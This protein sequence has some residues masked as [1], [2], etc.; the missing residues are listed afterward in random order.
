M[1]IEARSPTSA[2][3]QMDEKRR[4]VLVGFR[5]RKTHRSGAGTAP[6]P[7]KRTL[8]SFS[9]QTEEKSG[10]QSASFPT[11]AEPAGQAVRVPKCLVLSRFRSVLLSVLKAP[12]QSTL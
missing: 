10:T 9:G 2:S 3:G 6:R 8:A 5:I 4:K 1:R 12:F 11:R 7:P